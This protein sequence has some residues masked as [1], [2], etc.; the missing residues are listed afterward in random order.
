MCTSLLCARGVILNNEQIIV[1]CVN[2]SFKLL[3]VVPS[4]DV[5][6]TEVA[7]P[8]QILL[9]SMVQKRNEFVAS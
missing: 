9:F 7:F 2:F 6:V 4:D 5:R 8:F 3:Q 1:A